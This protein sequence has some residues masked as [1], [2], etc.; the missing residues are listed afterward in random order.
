MS[1]FNEEEEEYIPDPR[2]NYGRGTGSRLRE[3]HEPDSY[4]IEDDNSDEEP[5]PTEVI[6]QSEE[7]KKAP[8]YKRSQAITAAGVGLVAFMVGALLVVLLRWNRKKE[9]DQAPDASQKGKPNIPAPKSKIVKRTVFVDASKV[10]DKTNTKQLQQAATEIIDEEE[11]DDA[12]PPV[13]PKPKT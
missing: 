10:K 8:F 2:D 13:K 7:P 9:P 4:D 5:I 1:E 11:D 6:V 12:V 3:E